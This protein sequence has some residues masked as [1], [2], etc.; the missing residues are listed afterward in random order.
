M[1][2]DDQ[3]KGYSYGMQKKTLLV[4]LLVHHPKILFL[5]EPTS[6]AGSEERTHCQG[7]FCAN[8]VSRVCTVLYDNT[9]TRNRRTDLRPG[10][11]YQ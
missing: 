2:A 9:Y 8:A 1:S 6:G 11:H 7:N 3:I 10:W 5:D 4:S